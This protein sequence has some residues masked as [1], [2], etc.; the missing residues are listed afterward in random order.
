MS[1]ILIVEDDD[2]LRDVM[3]DIL[4]SETHEVL[5]ARDGREALELF[6]DFCPDLIVSDISMPRMDG[7]TLLAAIREKPI[8]ATVP[9]LFTSAL[10]DRSN[11]NRAR[12]LGMDD[13]LFKPFDSRELLD[14]VDVRLA[15]REG[16]PGLFRHVWEQGCRDDIR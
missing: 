11:V 15:R 5:P 8:G 12:R 9:F 16:I 13:Y 1:R 4:Q 10:T 2:M 7:F 6:E 3:K 14:A